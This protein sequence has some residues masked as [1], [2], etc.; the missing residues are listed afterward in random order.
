MTVGIKPDNDFPESIEM[1]VANPLKWNAEYPVLYKLRLQL[2]SDAG[3]EVIEKKIGFRE[4]TVVGNQLFLNGSAIKLHGVNRH[5]V[6][7]LTGRSLNM[8]LW[9]KDALLYKEA[10][11]NYIRTS[12]Y[13]PAEEFIDLCDSAGFYVELENPLVWIG[14]NANLNMKFREAWDLRLRKELIKTTRETITFYRN[15]PGIIIWSLANESAWT[16][17][18]RA[19]H[20]AADSLDPTRP[21]TFH[22]QAYGDYNNYGSISMPIANIHY[23]GP[24]GPDMAEN[25]ERPLLFGEYC[26]LNTYNRQ[27]IAT[28]PGVRDAWVQGFH[29]MWERMYKSK[30]CLGGALWSGIDDAFMLPEGKLVG[31]GEWGPIDGWR[32]MKPEYYHVKKTYSPV[33]INNRKELC[34]C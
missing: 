8:E 29:S 22:D 30:G 24:K 6:H 34:D 2:T 18:W 20:E 1:D 21:K 25:F 10:N 28:D 12:H 3:T 14:H 5:E 23:P 17:N 11:V 33:I 31:Y 19:A 26:H 27:E 16:D 13:P 9:R 32:R 4:L 15:H 7:P